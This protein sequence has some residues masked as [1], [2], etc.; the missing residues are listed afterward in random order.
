MYLL[1]I[2]A[3]EKKHKDFIYENSI[4]VE[5]FSNQSHLDGI[6]IAAYQT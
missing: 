6:S 4:S 3:L 5:I 1:Q 2:L